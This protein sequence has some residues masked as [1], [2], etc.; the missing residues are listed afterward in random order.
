MGTASLEVPELITLTGNNNH[1]ALPDVKRITDIRKFMDESKN[2]N[3][4]FEKLSEF[5]LGQE[6]Q[7]HDITKLLKEQVQIKMD[8]LR[9]VKEDMLE[10]QR[11]LKAPGAS[12]RFTKGHKV[13]VKFYDET[14]IN[15][16][17]V[18]D[19]LARY[20]LKMSSLYGEILALDSDVDYV[21]YLASIARV[22]K[23][24]VEDWHRHEKIEKA[25]KTV[26]KNKSAGDAK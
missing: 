24:Y 6:Q 25:R 18:P 22:N 5:I 13:L 12:E 4:S 7:C 16:Y 14:E 26:I 3:G 11:Q 2:I 15:E 20:S 19:A 21:A 9:Q 10:L 17:E 8:A 1:L 23:D